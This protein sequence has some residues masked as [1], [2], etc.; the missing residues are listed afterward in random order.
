MVDHRQYIPIL[1]GKAGEYDALVHLS[2]G[3]KPQLIPIIEVPPIEWKYAGPLGT[4]S[5]PKRTI[6][7]HVNEIPENIRRCWGTD[8]PVFIDLLHVGEYDSLANGTHPLA[9]VFD[10][11]RRLGVQAIPVTGLHRSSK[12]QNAVIDAVQRDGQGVCI[13]V[14]RQQCASA[15]SLVSQLQRLLPTLNVAFGEVDLILDLGA[16]SQGETSELR[17]IATSAVSELPNLED[18]RRIALAA[19]AMPGSVTRDMNRFSVKRIPRVEW[20][21]WQGIAKAREVTRIPN[22]SD[23]GVNHPEYP[24]VDW[25]EISLGGKIRYTAKELWVI[26]KGCK[27]EDAGDQFHKLAQK[28][29]EQPEFCSR[30]FSWGDSRIASCANLESGPGNLTNWIAFTTNHHLR[31]VTQQLANGP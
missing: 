4:P 23:Y 19:T 13:R 25:R 28:L 14:D 26:V 29:R 10:Q 7:E 17:T 22:F 24:D 1:K 20:R 30:S 31:F 2:P 5:E 21:V 18:W 8:L 27:L 11:C 15:T 3:V 16:I 9:Y 12:Y 6:D